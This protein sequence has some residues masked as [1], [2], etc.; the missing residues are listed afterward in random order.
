MAGSYPDVP[1][2]RMA[3]DADGTVAFHGSQ[4]GGGAL[5]EFTALQMAELND[6]DDT[7]VDFGGAQGGRFHWQLFPELRE[8]DGFY[9]S[10]S[11]A[12]SQAA[13]STVHTSATTTNGRDGTWTQ[14][15]ASAAQTGTVPA[16]YRTSIISTAVSSIRGVRLAQAG[17]AGTNAQVL[18]GEHLYGEI[19]PGQTPDRLLWI[20]VATGLEFTA[21][22]D[23]GNV[24][25]GSSR[26][27]NLRLRNNSAALTAN[28][29]Q[30]TAESLY[31]AS[32]S[33]YTF[34]LPGGSTFQSTRQ[35]ASLAP[36]TSSGIIVARQVVPNTETLGLHAGRMFATVATWT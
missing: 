28:T 20:D 6:E 17:T 36:A 9:A 29:I 11:G 2:R 19:S 5:T 32:G 27:R 15:I 26:D 33:W 14:Q 35:V 12:S 22:V 34:T 25:R 7:G 30:Y 3:W 24:P 8:L 1:G 23:Y 21:A 4:D 18:A 13:L 16:T 31:L 10:S